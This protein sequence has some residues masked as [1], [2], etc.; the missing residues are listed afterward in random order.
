MKDY[1]NVDREKVIE[2][3][4]DVTQDPNMIAME[5]GLSNDMVITIL[6]DLQKNGDIE[7][8]TKEVRDLNESI[9]TN[10]DVLKL[11]D[12]IDKIKQK[13][14]FFDE[15][16][17]KEIFGEGN[18]EIYVKK[19]KISPPIVLGK[20]I[21]KDGVFIDIDVKIGD[22]MIKDIFIYTD[23]EYRVWYG[24]TTGQSKIK[25]LK[26]LVDINLFN[27]LTEEVI[28]HYVPEDF[29]DIRIKRN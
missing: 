11:H 17:E 9:I 20:K 14:Y 29:F 12:L 16:E 5:S 15:K 26:K 21:Y 7:G 4:L 24:S 25:E 6:D 1:N 8:W 28:D 13:D 22:K 27:K 18:I 23:I 2:L 10:D 19:V 3:W